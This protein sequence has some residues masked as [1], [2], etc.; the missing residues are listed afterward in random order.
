[1]LND[2]FFIFFIQNFCFFSHPE[3]FVPAH[4][5]VVI[6]VFQEVYFLAYPPETKFK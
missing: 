1:M 6:A 4:T 2:Y 5:F 3:P